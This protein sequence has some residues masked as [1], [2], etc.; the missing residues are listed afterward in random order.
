MLSDYFNLLLDVNLNELTPSSRWTENNHR[1]GRGAAPLQEGR[2][3]GESA[4]AQPR[5][6]QVPPRQRVLDGEGEKGLGRLS[7]P[8]PFS[9]LP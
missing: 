8:T 5:L 3:T 1:R 9:Q 2:G 6:P 4:E 7:S